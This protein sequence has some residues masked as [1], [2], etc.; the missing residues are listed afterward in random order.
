MSGSVLAAAGWS[1]VQLA[2]G[3]AR[4]VAAFRALILTVA[5]G[6]TVGASLWMGARKAAG[7]IGRR[8]AILLVASSWFIAGGIAALP[9]RLW[10]MLETG[11]AAS[12]P[13]AG[14]VDCYFEAMSGLTTTGATILPDVESLPR[15]MLLWRSITHWLGGLGIVVLFVAVLPLLGVGGKHLYRVE[16]PGPKAGGGVRPRIQ[17]TARVLWLIYVG[18]TLAE[19][20][21][22]WAAGMSLFDAVC[23]TFATLATGGFSTQNASVAAYD[24]ALIDAIIVAFMLAAGIN[25]GLYFQALRGG[26]RQVYRDPELR[27]YL[28]ILSV[29]SLF[30]IVMVYGRTFTTTA[31]TQVPSDLGSA[32]RHGLFTVVS[33]LTTTGFCTAD[34]EHWSFPV[35]AVL[36]VLMYVGGCA[37]STGGGLKVIRC[38]MVFKIIWGE[39]E[40]VF[41]PRAV[42][43][44][45]V[46][47]AV[48]DSDMKIS[49]LVY[50]L[51]VVLLTA[52]GAGVIMLLER[53][54]MIDVTTAVSATAATLNN[55][56]PGLNQVGA[57]RNY[58]WFTDGSK[59]VMTVL[60]ALG[61]LELF[62]ILVLLSPRYWK[63]D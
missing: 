53:G 3:D 15:S 62:T 31:G 23:H 2:L 27:C 17:E 19:I 55:I 58:A 29:A 41:R 47:N 59:C 37:G 39:L 36:L 14:F 32:V 16:A 38:L 21:A 13:F 20:V 4:E 26:W 10:S 56:G 40:H 48:I 6:G 24:S 30:V 61:R 5:I 60:M 50:V 42:R 35:H 18:L 7:D 54:K 12:A 46:G 22:L 28:G 25:F 11:A 63:S 45:H 57:S 49:T 51:S 9:Y 43:A 44:L 33:I 34:F 52:A 8:E 1:W